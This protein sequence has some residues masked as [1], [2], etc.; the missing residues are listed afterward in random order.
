MEYRCPS[1]ERNDTASLASTK[2]NKDSDTQG[3]GMGDTRDGVEREREA[4]VEN[5]L[6]RKVGH[7]HERDRESL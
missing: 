1:E 3:E 2:E 6:K 4:H 7:I 5:E